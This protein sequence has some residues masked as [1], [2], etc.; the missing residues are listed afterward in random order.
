[1]WPGWGSTFAVAKCASDQS[2]EIF[3][4]DRWAFGG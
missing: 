4:A 3:E 2:D 1:M